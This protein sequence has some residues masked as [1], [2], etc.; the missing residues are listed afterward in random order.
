LRKRKAGDVSYNI[1]SSNKRL[2]KRGGQKMRKK[3]ERNYGESSEK[4]W[5][6]VAN[7]RKLTI[8]PQIDVKLNHAWEKVH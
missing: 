3:V 5:K 1:L 8:V 4:L 2:K 6:K 7:T